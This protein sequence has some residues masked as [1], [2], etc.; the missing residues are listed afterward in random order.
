MAIRLAKPWIELAAANVAALPGQ[1]GVF[2]LAD[3]QG[4]VV[5]IGYAGGRSLFGLRGELERA[6]RERPGGA[7]RFRYEV[8]QQY[9]SRHRELLMLHVA[10]HGALPLVNGAD[11]P[12][13]L[14]R[15]SPL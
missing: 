4:S 9:T 1:L 5:F 10:D 11:P 3:P 6:L 13:G 2:E 8:N 15:L 14:G 7:T 12:P